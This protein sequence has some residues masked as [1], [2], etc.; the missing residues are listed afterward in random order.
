MTAPLDRT[1]GRKIECLLDESPRS[2]MK[3][4]NFQ[5]QVIGIVL[6]GSTPFWFLLFL[7]SIYYKTRFTRLSVDFHDNT[8]VDFELVHIVAI[9]Y[10]KF[11]KNREPLTWS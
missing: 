6:K 4:K 10:A 9:I 3:S 2:D 5:N 8:T 11:K 1:Y 7:P